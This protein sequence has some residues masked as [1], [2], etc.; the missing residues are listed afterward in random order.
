MKGRCPLAAPS[1]CGPGENFTKRHHRFE[2]DR[3]VIEKN[4][5]TLI[6]ARN[7]PEGSFDGQKLDTP[8][9]D[10]HVAYFSGEA[11]WTPFR[12]LRGRSNDR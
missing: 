6:E 2:P 10:V 4:D 8:W 7:N 9:N 12:Q 3:V 5:G 11:L 1:Q